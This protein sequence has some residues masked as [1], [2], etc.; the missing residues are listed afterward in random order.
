MQK[1]L[2]LFIFTLTLFADNPKV[3]AKLGDSIYDNLTKIEYLKGLEAYKELR[4]KID[5]YSSRVKKAKVFGFAVEN[6]SRA[7]VKLDYLKEIRSLSKLNHYFERSAQNN[8]I[9]AIKMKNNDLFIGIV[10]S[11]FIDTLKHKKK[12]MNYYNQNK[13]FINPEGVIQNFIDEAYAKKHK[14]RWKPKT[15][16]QLQEEKIKRLRK[17]DKLKEEAL[18]RRLAAEVKAKKKKIREEQEKELF[19]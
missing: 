3:Y 10:N 12:I 18:E 6:G 13:K 14:K 11:G 16:K 5:I 2:L 17:N 19:R 7:N 4:G 1:L 15:K 8:F 9:S